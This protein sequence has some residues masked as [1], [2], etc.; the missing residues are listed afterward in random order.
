M[1][2][3]EGT[4]M[5]T[6]TA[7]ETAQVS[8]AITANHGG[9]YAFRL[10]RADSPTLDEE[11][12]QKGH[13]TFT[14]S[15]QQVIDVNGT[16]VAEVPARRTAAGTH[17]AGSQWTRNPIPQEA[18]LG[19]KIPNLPNLYGRGPFPYNLLDEVAVPKD[20]TPGHYVLSF[21][22][23]AEQTKQVW[24]HCSDVLVVAAGT[25]REEAAAQLAAV[26]DAAVAESPVCVG[27]SIGLST[28]DCAAWVAFYDALDGDS[29]PASWKKS[30]DS[31]RSDPC[32]CEG[33]WQKFIVCS[34][35]RDF[36][37]ITEIYLLSND[38]RGTIPP[39]FTGMKHLKSLSLVDTQISGSLPLEM[40]SMT[41][42]EMIWLD[43]NPSLGG[44]I[45]ESLL[46]LSNLSVLELHRSNF[47][48]VLPALDFATIQD[49]TLNN[50]VFD[51]PLPAGAETCGAVCR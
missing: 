38:I 39:A 21:R 46:Q 40:G 43:H 42:L 47:T 13:L 33:T 14:N 23:D 18:D 27:A 35:F 28:D 20:L 29:W 22:W 15:M 17:P 2:D 24:S 51:C 6:W 50:L 34:A 1:L 9:G 4:P 44:K 25:G 10:C 3:L 7:G 31:L 5:D 19:P 45:P 32:G 26:Q 11:C 8:W 36:A 30:C 37:H 49:C 41:G 12:F 48:G 16:V